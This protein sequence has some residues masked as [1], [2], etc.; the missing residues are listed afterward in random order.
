MPAGTK[1]MVAVPPATPVT[2]P[3]TPTVAI[4]GTEEVHVPVPAVNASVDAG[5]IVPVLPLM[6]GGAI[7][8][9]SVVTEQPVFM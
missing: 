7:T 2:T 6:P 8:F 4:V 9:T 3:V 1:L 5:H